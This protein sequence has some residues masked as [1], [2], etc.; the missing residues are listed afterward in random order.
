MTEQ[1][2]KPYVEII[3]LLRRPWADGHDAMLDGTPRTA[4]PHP[5]STHKHAEWLIGWDMA[6]AD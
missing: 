4:N 2:K 5:P 6:N 3:V 1:D